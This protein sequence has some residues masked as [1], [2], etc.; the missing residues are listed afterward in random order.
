LVLDQAVAP[1]LRN[2][3]KAERDR[4]LWIEYRNWTTVDE[5]LAL[6]EAAPR[7]VDGKSRLDTS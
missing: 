4:L 5:Y 1:V 2:Q 3:P 7:A 6:N